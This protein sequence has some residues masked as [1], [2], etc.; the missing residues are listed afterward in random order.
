MKFKEL[1]PT[2]RISLFWQWHATIVGSGHLFPPGG[3]RDRE[4][5]SPTR[6]NTDP[7]PRTVCAKS[8]SS[9]RPSPPQVCGGEGVIQ[10]LPKSEI[11]A[12][13]Q[14][15]AN[16]KWRGACFFSHLPALLLLRHSV[17]HRASGSRFGHSVP[18]ACFPL[19]KLSPW[20]R[21]TIWIF[22]SASI[23]P[24]LTSMP[25]MAFTSGLRSHF[26]FSASVNANTSSRNFLRFSI[27][28]HRSF[29]TST[30]SR[31]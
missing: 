9:P 10:S 23:I 18:R 11:R 1:L 13:R 31:Q 22:S 26:S 25:S 20:P 3:E 17:H 28:L 8:A 6:E 4:R 2:R 24:L 14:V 15:A 5:G 7:V 30:V 19:T 12:V 16:K 27:R 21:P 29:L